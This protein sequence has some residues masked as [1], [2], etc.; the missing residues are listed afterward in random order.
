[1]C[2]QYNYC[3]WKLA[4][5]VSGGGVGLLC[6]FWLQAAC[7]ALG[8]WDKKES[9]SSEE[10]KHAL[11]HTQTEVYELLPDSLCVLVSVCACMCMCYNSCK[12][13]RPSPVKG[14]TRSPGCPSLPVSVCN[15]CR[16]QSVGGWGVGSGEWGICSGK[17]KKTCYTNRGSI[18]QA[19]NT[20]CKEQHFQHV[21]S[22]KK[23]KWPI[24]NQIHSCWWEGCEPELQFYESLTWLNRYMWQMPEHVVQLLG[25]EK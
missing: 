14:H 1:M 10:K 12:A 19:H 15:L 9:R 4:Q 13:I 18:V 7:D 11:C 24:Y 16:K 22:T 6:Y 21:I 8:C 3:T 2:F 23:K 20:S 17:K 25:S 5:M